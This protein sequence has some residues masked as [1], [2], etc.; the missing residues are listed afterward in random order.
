M[1]PIDLEF[2]RSEGKVTMVTSVKNVNMVF[3]LENCLPQSF[4]IPHADWSW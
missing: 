1:T 4:Y 2:T 3:A